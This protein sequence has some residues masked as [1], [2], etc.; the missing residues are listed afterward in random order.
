MR[1]LTLF[2]LIFSVRAFAQDNDV[3]RIDSLPHQ[4]LLMDKGW[5][6]YAGDDPNFAKA[7]FDDSEWQ[8]LTLADYSIYIPQ[9]KNKN[10]GW[11]RANFI[12]D[13]TLLKSPLAIQFT[14]LGAS[15]IYLNGKLF[16]QFGY[17]KSPSN[18]ESFNPGNK[19]FLLPANSGTKISIAIRFA[20]HIPS[21]TWLFTNAS[22]KKSPL[23]FT[24]NTWSNALTQYKIALESAGL[25]PVTY[26]FSVLS[27]LFLLL[28]AFFQ[29]KKLIFFLVYFASFV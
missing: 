4:G 28:F 15:E 18:I 20:S 22:T 5:K 10:I 29:K 23:S 14:Q 16:Q 25:P 12:I 26:M 17:I 24:I 11:F 8:S 19:P 3:F 13:T 9:L 6:F 1:C 21:K 7:N 2:L 27:F